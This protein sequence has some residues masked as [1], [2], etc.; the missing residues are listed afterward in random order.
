MFNSKLIK[1]SEQINNIRESCHLL[2][3]MMREIA[4]LV[5]IGTTPLEIDKFAYDWI[6]S[7]DSKPNFLG[8]G[9]FPNSLCIG[10]NDMA[11]HGIPTDRPFED[12]DIVTIDAGLLYNG[13]NSDMARTYLVGNVSE[14]KKK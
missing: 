12:G 7:H 9:K 14:D 4:P 2:A 5:K 8:Y 6:I 3:Q 11:T 13:M 1:T 10:V